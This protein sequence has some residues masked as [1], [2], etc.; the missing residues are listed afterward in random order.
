[1]DSSSDDEGYTQRGGDNS[2]E[3]GGGQSSTE[4][5]ASSSSSRASDELAES[6]VD[7]LRQVRCCEC[8]RPLMR[9]GRPD[10]ED[11]EV[12]DGCHRCFHSSCCRRRR[13]GETTGPV[14]AAT[15]A[16]SGEAAG[17]RASEDEGLW[18]HCEACRRI[19]KVRC[20]L[21]TV[22]DVFDAVDSPQLFGWN[23]AFPM[24][25]L[26]RSS[27]GMR[28]LCAQGEI[29]LPEVPRSP[30]DDALRGDAKNSSGLDREE[31]GGVS[32][33]PR[34]YTLQVIHVTA[35]NPGK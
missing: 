23:H 5:D 32:N 25:L 29:D 27:Q 17:G 2:S 28:D 34:G 21:L 16:G 33:A 24:L 31:D 8:R 9:A 26:L 14:H 3:G 11:I 6:E 13:I 18:F 19:Y 30:T 7:Q 4:A 15:A 22:S 1:M 10:A 20:I 35:V 12:C